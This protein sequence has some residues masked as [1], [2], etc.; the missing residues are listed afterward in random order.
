MVESM[1]ISPLPHK[2][3]GLSRTPESTSSEETIPTSEPRMTESPVE[4]MKPPPVPDRKLAPP[5]RPILSRAKGYSTTAVGTKSATYPTSQPF[6]FGIPA[7]NLTLDDCFMES[8]PRNGFNPLAPP[9]AMRPKSM[10]QKPSVFGQPPTIGRK[11]CAPYQRPRKQFRRSL[12]MFEHPEDVMHQQA[13]PEPMQSI[14]DLD[15]GPQ[16]QLPHFFQDQESVPRIAKQT[17]VDILDGKYVECYSNS[18]VVDCRFEYE[19]KG[20]HIDGA[21]NFNDKEELARTLLES[22]ARNTLII[23]HCEYSAHRAPIAARFLR[24]EDRNVNAHQYPKLTY[25]EVYIL[26]GGYSSFFKDFKTR[27]YPQNYVEMNDAEFASACERG[28]GRIKQHRSKLS[29]A[30]TFAFGQQHNESPTAAPRQPTSS[31]LMSS[32]DIVMESSPLDPAKRFDTKRS[33]SY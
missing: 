12:S 11:A 6:T 24:G 23:L 31:S 15:E 3:P 30:Q 16:L 27:C 17:M 28:L 22:P 29:R 1:D 7:P 19:Y 21:V 9:V 32:M 20:G 25:P 8:P 33:V 4:V 14:M 5:P 13:E 18:I 10:S 26:D 2:A